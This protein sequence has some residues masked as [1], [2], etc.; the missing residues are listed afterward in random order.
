M[1]EYKNKKCTILLFLI[2]SS[3]AMRI[4]AEK[5]YKKLVTFDVV[6]PNVQNQ[7]NPWVPIPKNTLETKEKVVR[8]KQM[9]DRGSGKQ[10]KEKGKIE[11]KSKKRKGKLV[12][13]RS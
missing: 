8:D 5:G 11:I 13:R 3:G 1:R 12:W 10:L 7:K 9:K 4:K 2:Q 6:L